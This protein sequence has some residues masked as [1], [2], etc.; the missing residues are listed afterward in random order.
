MKKL[1]YELEETNNWK[2]GDKESNYEKRKVQM[3]SSKAIIDKVKK[4]KKKYVKR[5][6]PR[7]GV[8]WNKIKEK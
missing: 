3:T 8:D 6:F 1:Y 4:T 7:K 5:K 2:E